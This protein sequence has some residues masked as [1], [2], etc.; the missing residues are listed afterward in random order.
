M[1]IRDSHTIS[2]TGDGRYALISASRKDGLGNLDI[3]KVEFN[4]TLDH[5]FKTVITGNVISETGTRISLSKVSL[6]NLESHEI[7]DYK[8]ASTGNYFVLNAS[9]GKYSLLVEGTNFV[10]TT[11]EIN[12]ENVFPPVEVHHD[13]TVKPS[14]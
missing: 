6:E 3:W 1:C 7:L 2:F 10:T 4:D 8:P 13:I 14:K 11:I 5:P 9:P 12:I